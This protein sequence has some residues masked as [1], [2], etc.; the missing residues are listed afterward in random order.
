MNTENI[1][2]ID[3]GPFEFEWNIFP[4]H[5]TVEILQKIQKMTIRRTRLAWFG[6]L[7][8][9]MSVSNDIDWTKN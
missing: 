6:D 8:I 2:G 7:I 9:F 5:A 4:G 3:G 1:F